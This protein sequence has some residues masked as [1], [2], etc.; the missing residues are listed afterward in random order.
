MDWTKFTPASCLPD[1]WCE[2]P[3]IGS[4]ILEPVN[5]WTNLIFVLFGLFLIFFDKKIPYG[6]NFLSI[7]KLYSRVYGWALIFLGFGSFLF[8]ASQ[9][10][11][12]Q[13]FDVFGMYLVS[14]FF[15]VYNLIRLKLLK[16]QSFLIYYSLSCTSLGLIIYFFPDTRRWLFG[17]LILLILFQIIYTNIKLKS[18]FKSTYLIISILTYLMGQ[19]L[20]YLD[21]SK[22][23]CHPYAL[24]N[25]HGL[26]H[27]LTGISSMT[28]FLYFAS[29]KT[30]LTES[31]PS[32]QV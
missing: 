32:I 27:L 20:W 9:T 16:P 28:I 5:S 13:W 31:D 7:N 4:F 23:W 26:W 25:G 3:R 14:T 8:H 29:E 12:G 21:K 24:M 15:A 6:L 22:I 30:T 17:F 18:I 11:V 2:A 19:F 10:F 1:C